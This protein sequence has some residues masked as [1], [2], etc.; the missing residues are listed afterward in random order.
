M[1]PIFLSIIV[2]GAIGL[3]GGL[4]LSIAS[5]LMEVK[6]DEKVE[7]LRAILPGANCGACGYTG[8]DC[9][10][11]ALACGEA[12]PGA[13]A[14]GGAVMNNELGKMLGVAVEMAEPQAAAVLCNGTCDKV[15]SK[16]MYQGVDSCKGAN[17]L[18]AGTS[19]CNYGCLG[20]GDCQ[21][22]CP[23]GAIEVQDGCA[24]VNTELCTACG[25]C[26]KTCPKGIITLLPIKTKATVVC[27][28]KDKG[29]IARK[30]CQSACIGCGKCVK[31]CQYDAVKVENNLS[32]IDPHKCTACGECV[33]ACPT[34]CIVI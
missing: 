8:C 18:Y 32:V 21:R 34:N 16:M 19:D 7:E 25:L 5:V 4:I 11:E 33:K 17:M 23:Y 12:K 6:S 10:A 24:V 13:C 28:N 14:P 3:I 15:G 27:S 22:V 30:A 29:A 26:V 20:F 1:N 2:V 31:A 9:Y